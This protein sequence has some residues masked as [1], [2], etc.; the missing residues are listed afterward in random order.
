MNLDDLKPGPETDVLVANSIG[1]EGTEGYAF[2]MRDDSGQ[3]KY[4][5]IGFVDGKNVS[6]FQ[7]STNL[8]DA[9]W[10]AEHAGLFKLHVLMKT[11][12]DKIW[13]ICEAV[14]DGNDPSVIGLFEENMKAT[15][16]TPAMAICLA[17]QKLEESTV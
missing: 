16:D 8:N 10:A 17:I 9:F 5:L 13:V 15:A 2:A 3:I 11:D 12:V 7:P 6:H 4:V 14:F 1:C